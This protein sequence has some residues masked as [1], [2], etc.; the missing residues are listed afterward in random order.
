MRAVT[1]KRDSTNEVART[2]THHARQ[3]FEEL[4]QIHETVQL[5]AELHPTSL[6][7]WSHDI[8]IRVGAVPL[9]EKTLHCF[10]LY[11]LQQMANPCIFCNERLAPTNFCVTVAGHVIQRVPPTH[12]KSVAG[13]MLL[14][15]NICR[16]VLARCFQ[17]R[18]SKLLTYPG[19]V[20]CVVSKGRS[21]AHQNTATMHTIFSK[22]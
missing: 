6:W 15:K 7:H 5:Q 17:T 2:D 14:D 22:N 19:L 9:P 10:S 21:L 4:R 3:H 13:C 12:M 1:E 18:M 16:Y 11:E 8:D 20:C